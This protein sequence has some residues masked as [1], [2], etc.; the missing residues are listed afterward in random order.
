MELNFE[1]GV[2]L[3]KHTTFQVGGTANLFVCI[4]NELQLEAAVQYGKKNELPIRILGGGSNILAADEGFSGLII[5]NEITGIEVLSEDESVA[6]LRV[7]AGENLD[8]LVEFCAE[9]EYWGIENLS[10]IPG[11]VGAAP[12]QNVGAYGVEIESVVTKVRAYHVP[13]ETFAEFTTTECAFSYRDSF[14]KSDTGREYIVTAVEFSLRTIPQPNLSYKDLQSL[15]S[16]AAV[17][18]QDIRTAVIGIRAAKFPD[19]TTVGTAGSF[20]KNPIIDQAHYNELCKSYPEL[21]GFSAGEG[22]VKVPL[23]W[24]LDKVCQIRGVQEGAVGS[25]EGQALVV[26]NY[27]GASAT[28]IKNFAEKI[29][30]KVFTDTKI[31][32]E[33]EV[34]RW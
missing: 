11:T 8:A 26:V 33:W 4:Q 29:S 32:I 21:P 18:L 5:K 25:Y 17:T 27:G 34:T 7:G 22:R 28:E 14:F 23:G 10:H 24:I 9:K 2:L 6:E 19:W 31:V 15:Q 12:I 3:S 30:Q 16:E 13:T 20:F 1:Q